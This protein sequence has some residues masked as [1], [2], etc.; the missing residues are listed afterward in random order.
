MSINR[1]NHRFESVAHW[2][3]GRLLFFFEYD[4]ELVEG[5]EYGSLYAIVEVMKLHKTS[6]HTKSIP[7]VQPFRNNDTKKYAVLDVADIRSVVGLI[8]KTDV[9]N[10]KVESANW[11]YV[12]SPS[13]AFDQDMS[14]NAGKIGDL[15]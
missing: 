2:F 1:V 7:M 6:P 4:L 8:Q 14:V 3:V 12:I 9:V 5:R 10:N 13:T 15:L 11:F